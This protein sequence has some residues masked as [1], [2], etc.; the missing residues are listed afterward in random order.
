[1]KTQTAVAL[2]LGLGCA[3]A[4]SAAELRILNQN[5]SG[6][7]FNDTTPATPVGLNFG[8][9]KGQ[10]ALIAYQY[11]ATIWGATLKS[12]VPIL[13]DSAFVTIAEDSEFTCS[14]SV[15]LLGYA[16]PVSY[17]TGGGLPN[18]Q[19]AYVVA[20]ANAIAGQDFTPG[21]PHIQAR[22]NASIGTPGCLTASSWYLGLDN[23]VAAGQSALL[24]TL[25][26]EFGHGLGFVSFVNINT[27]IASPP[28]IF[29]FHVYDELI[30]GIWS[31]IQPNQRVPL[32][33]GVNEISWDGPEV[34]AEI[35]RF[36]GKAP[37]LEFLSN[38]TSTTQQVSF[39][40][41]DFSGP[42][43][44][45]AA[46]VVAVT[47]LDAC[48]DLDGGS[49]AGKIGLIERGNCNFIDKAERAAASGASGVVIFDHD[50]GPLV[51]MGGAD[52]GSVLDVPAVFISNHDGTSVLSQLGFGD[53][54]TGSF[55]NSSQTAN[56][57]SS[58]Q[59]ILLYTPSTLS[60]GST[61]SHWN[62]QGYP[63]GLLMEPF[64][65][66]TALVDMDVTPATMQ[67]MG[68]QVNNGLT[69]GITKTLESTFVAGTTATYLM[70]VINR[71]TTDAA[72]VQLD[73]TFPAGTQVLA[74]RTIA[75][76]CT[77]LPCALG[78]VA[79]GEVRPVFVTVQI[80]TTALDPF[81]AT[82]T[83]SAPDATGTDNLTATVSTPKAT[84]GGCG[85]TDVPALALTLLFALGARL[86][87]RRSAA[88]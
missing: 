60:P 61:L 20:L 21:Q 70:A 28:A 82:T 32:M 74:V 83:L 13:I 40:P 23:N 44:A 55:G 30:G 31:G 72:S 86:W 37:V 41:G 6:Q 75:G 5:A 57:D 12:S 73:A 50:A 22:F 76:G 63:H 80:P 17:E 54:V 45:G 47:P 4:A 43:D 42:L 27:G 38:A 66:P 56:T 34:T 49:L 69:V 65:S 46:P 26:H 36:L 58:Q 35:P 81:V 67:D 68:W 10:Q 62:N 88:R 79:A 15:G 9:T 1:M 77:A 64:L 59:R 3:S 85:T 39:L 51:E 7:G 84:S 8:T 2:A 19:A 29:D 48:S 25:L 14:A 52:S 53:T 18:P 33:V 87:T 11:A 78:T 16:R 71:R 24:V